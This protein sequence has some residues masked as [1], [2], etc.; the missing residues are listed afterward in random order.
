MIRYP[1]LRNLTYVYDVDGAE[2]VHVS[3]IQ[4]HHE[5]ATLTSL[6]AILQVGR[7]QPAY[8]HTYIDRRSGDLAVLLC[9][10]LTYPTSWRRRACICA[11]PRGRAWAP[12]GTPA[13]WTA[14]GARRCAAC[15]SII[16]RSVNQSIN[17]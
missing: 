15:G 16:G 5:H 1:T 10:V 7:Q 3:G 2:G 11:G 13:A 6:G 4:I 12:S 17:Q 8:I 14:A 9:P